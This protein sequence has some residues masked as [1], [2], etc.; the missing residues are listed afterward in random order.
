MTEP[1][2]TARGEGDPEEGVRRTTGII[3]AGRVGEAD[4]I[5]ATVCHLLS[6]EASF[7]TGQTIVQDG[8]ETII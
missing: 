7:I 8:G 4:E 1:I 6:D 3:P 5:A 2:Y